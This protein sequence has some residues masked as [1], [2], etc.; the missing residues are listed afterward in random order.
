[1]LAS[2]FNKANLELCDGS[3]IP[4]SAKPHKWSALRL[5]TWLRVLKGISFVVAASISSPFK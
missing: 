3:F 4:F 1:M 5:N 2:R